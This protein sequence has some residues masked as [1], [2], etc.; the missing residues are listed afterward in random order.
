M[1]SDNLSQLCTW[2]YAAYGVHPDMKIHTG[3]GMS[4]GYGLVNCKSIKKIE[5]ENFY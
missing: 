4:F 3:G 2:V 5:E 1:R